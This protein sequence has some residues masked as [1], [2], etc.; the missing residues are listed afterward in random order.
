[1]FKLI[2]ICVT[3]AAQPHLAVSRAKKLPRPVVT[4]TII[5]VRGNALEEADAGVI[6]VAGPK[7]HGT[8]TVGWEKGANTFYIASGAWLKPAQL[9]QLKTVWSKEIQTNKITIIERGAGYTGRARTK[10]KQLGYNP[11]LNE[12]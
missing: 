1:M 6:L 12:E 7:A 2:L 3:L 11:K 9:T 5:I 8:F 10:L 4:D